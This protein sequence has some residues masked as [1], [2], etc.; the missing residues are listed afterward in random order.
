M[1]N[2]IVLILLSIVLITFII[3]N[4]HEIIQS[5]RFYKRLNKEWNEY[6]YLKHLDRSKEYY[7]LKYDIKEEQDNGQ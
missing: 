5:N 3:C 6:L 7:N 4:I 1:M 2:N